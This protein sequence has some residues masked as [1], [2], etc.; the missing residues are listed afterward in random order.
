MLWIGSPLTG[1]LCLLCAQWVKE[2]HSAVACGVHS[3]VP[4]VKSCP[5]QT[6]HVSIQAR[7]RKKLHYNYSKEMRRER[8]RPRWHLSKSRAP[9]A[10]HIGQ[11]L[12]AA[13]PCLQIALVRQPYS[14]GEGAPHDV[15][16]A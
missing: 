10:K 7:R 2:A 9:H 14:N 11:G 16:P 6:G 13:G 15:V 1:L 3:Q 8:G 5:R 4:A 12:E